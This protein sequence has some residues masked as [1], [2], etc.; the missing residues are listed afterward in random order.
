M[1]TMAIERQAVSGP[2]RSLEALVDRVMDALLGQSPGTAQSVARCVHDARRMR[3]AGDIDGA[4]TVLGGVD[5]R[6]ARQRDARWAH[7]EWLGLARR[8]FAGRDALV[9]SQGSGRAGRRPIASE[10]SSGR[11]RRPSLSRTAYPTPQ[12]SRPYR[13]GGPSSCALCGRQSSPQ[14]RTLPSPTGSAGRGATHPLP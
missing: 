6:G 11:G 7:A 5:T 4:L 9:Y 2:A 13:T 1:T 14:G 10:A 8:R 12:S 3:R